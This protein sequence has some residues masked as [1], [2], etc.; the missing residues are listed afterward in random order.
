M[1]RAFSIVICLLMLVACSTTRALM[2]TPNLYSSGQ[3][4]L[5]DELP[6]EL[7][8]N[9]VDLLY[10]TDRMPYKNEQGALMYV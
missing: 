2:P 5:F 9:S 6:N 7:Q 8:G 4:P 3:M 10:V 1:L